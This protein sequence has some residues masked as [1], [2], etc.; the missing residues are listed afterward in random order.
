MTRLLARGSRAFLAAAVLLVTPAIVTAD[1]V[2]DWNQIMVA[3]VATQNPFAQGRF[4]GITQLA[5]FEAVNAIA[6]AYQ[7]Y[8]GSVGAPALS[9]IHI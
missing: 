1:T 6:N 2:L 4:A 7:P 8:L 5:V 3:T 9:L